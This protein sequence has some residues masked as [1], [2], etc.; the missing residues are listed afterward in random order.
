M[1]NWESMTYGLTIVPVAICGLLVLFISIYKIV[2]ILGA[3]DLSK[4]YLNAIWLLG[5]LAF[6]LRIVG[7]LM[8]M[9]EMFFAISIAEVPDL[10]A[11]ANGLGKSMLYSLIGLAVLI[12]ALMFW[13]LIEALIVLKT[14][15]TIHTPGN[16]QG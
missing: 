9:S 14:P 13:G 2:R 7:Q 5:L 12:I 1:E 6:L 15:K 16:A 10:S 4:R 3:N 11:V 8:Y